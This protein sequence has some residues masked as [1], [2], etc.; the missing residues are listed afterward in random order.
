MS[1]FI[2]PNLRRIQA[3]I[4]V[5]KKRRERREAMLQQVCTEIRARFDRVNPLQDA[6]SAS[7][8]LD[9]GNPTASLERKR[10]R[11]LAWLG[12]R[13]LLHPDRPFKP[14]PKGHRDER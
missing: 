7:E 1:Q 6:V 14:Y 12:T 9:L 4:R 11:A 10:L 2:S 3:A 13:W 5:H 8:R